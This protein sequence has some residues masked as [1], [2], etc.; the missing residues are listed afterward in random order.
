MRTFIVLILSCASVLGAD[1]GIR[2]VTTVTTNAETSSIYTRDVFT[3]DGQTNLVRTTKTKG[4]MLAGRIQR[5]YHDG[6][7]VGDY[8]TFGD[9]SGFSTEAG[10]PYAVTFEFWPSKDVRSA[11]IGTK[12]GVILDAFTCTNGIFC[13]DES[14]RIAKANAIFGADKVEMKK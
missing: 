2:V 6:V 8:E 10:S 4:G 5:F 7:L 9:T 11:V 12:D 1:T 3:R 13:P 14:S